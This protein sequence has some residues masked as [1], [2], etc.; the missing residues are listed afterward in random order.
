[1]TDMYSPGYFKSRQ[2]C[3]RQGKDLGLSPLP[4][5]RARQDRDWS[6]TPGSL[7]QGQENGQFAE[8]SLEH[9]SPA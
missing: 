1:M 7:P 3:G 5:S 4:V 9:H 2:A 8:I 6:V